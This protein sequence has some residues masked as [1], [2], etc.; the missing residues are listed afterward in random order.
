MLTN[1]TLLRMKQPTIFAN[2]YTTNIPFALGM[3]IYTY[4][5]PAEMTIGAMLK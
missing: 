4:L 2:N 5:M 3:H 1:Q